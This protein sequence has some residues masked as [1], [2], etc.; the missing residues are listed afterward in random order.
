MSGRIRGV[1]ICR[2]SSEEQRKNNSL[3]RQRANVLKKAEELG[4]DIPEGYW[5]SGSVSSKRGKNFKRRDLLEIVSLCKKDK[6]IKCIIIDELDRFMRSMLELGY[7]WVTFR[8]LGVEVIFASQPGLGANTAADTLMMMLEA[9]KAEGSNEERQGKA[10]KGL[11]DALKLGKYPFHPKPGYRYGH[12]TGVHE[13]DELRG[14]A[15][16]HI[17]EQVAAHL[18]TPTQAV[19]E[20][21]RSDF[22]KGFAPYKMDKFR[23][24]ATDPFYA[25]IVEINKQIKVRNINGAHEALISIETH[26]KIIQVFNSKPK[27]QLGPLKNG[28]STYPCNNI[29]HC[30]KCKDKPNGRVVGFDHT[31]GKPNSKVYQRYRCR[32]CGTY[33]TRD[34]LHSMVMKQFEANSIT[35]DGQKL[36]LSALKTVWKQK[37]GD[38]QTEK[39]MLESRLAALE[40]TIEQQVEAA[41]NPANVT[42]K[43]D[44]MKSIANNK[45]EASE[46]EN[47]MSNAKSGVTADQE[48]FIKFALAWIDK[49]GSNFLSPD[50][51]R[52]NR[53]RCKQIVFSA[54][55]H[56]DRNQ[57]VYTP[58]ISP[59]ITLVTNKKDLSE[60]EKSSMVRV[61]GL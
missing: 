43:D 50:L 4:V 21:N 48:R 46:L 29:V 35:P 20:L 58:E 25:G 12:I 5:F 10:I 27:N 49:I 13:I 44:I 30:D 52:E 26:K 39:K 45:V 34:E 40:Q 19:R 23:K 14:P 17:L 31:N 42:I 33:L 2:V 53:L 15:L 55:F 9:F 54:D 7:F 18:L 59:L 32:S 51:S 22:A 11:T 38:A 37:E 24:I 8:E 57:K 47:R 61:R 3:N 56:L 36:L 1:A 41:I 6:S 16:K 60:T 28:N